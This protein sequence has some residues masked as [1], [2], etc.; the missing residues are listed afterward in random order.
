MT[1]A[2]RAEDAPDGISVFDGLNKLVAGIKAKTPGEVMGPETSWSPDGTRLVFSAHGSAS[3]TATDSEIFVINADGTGLTRLTNDNDNNLNASWS[4]DGELI[5]FHSSCNLRLIRPDGSRVRV[6]NSGEPGSG[7]FACVNVPRWS[8]D[9]AWLAFVG[10]DVD[11]F[12]PAEIWVIRRDGQSLQRIFSTAKS[13]LPWEATLAWSPDGNRLIYRLGKTAVQILTR[14]FK[15]GETCGKD[16]V[17]EFTGT[18][19][20]PWM[21]SFFPQWAGEDVPRFAFLTVTVDKPIPVYA[22]AG[23][24]VPAINL[25]PAGDHLYV[26]GEA[27]NDYFPVMTSFGQNGWGAAKSLGFHRFA[28]RGNVPIR[29][30]PST[31]DEVLDTLASAP[32]SVLNVWATGRDAANLWLQILYQGRAGWIPFPHDGDVSGLQTLP[33]TTDGK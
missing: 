26:H 6:I 32:D 28:F 23:P 31:N 25:V 3:S 16:S 8:P 10:T 29:T 20:S 21:P 18:V 14:C 7:R 27:T 2:R 5:A 11:H 4:P 17:S 22:L 33:V 15:Q 13:G 9:G 30:G 1:F 12:D 24:A 19:P